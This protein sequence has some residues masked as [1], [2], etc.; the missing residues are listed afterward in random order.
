MYE[1]D[2]GLIY[3]RARYYSPAL[4][5]FV[6]AD[7]LHGDITNALSLNRYSFCNGDPAN[8]VDPLGLSW[9]RGNVSSGKSNAVAFGNED[10]SGKYKTAKMAVLGF[11]SEYYTIG[12]YL[13][14]ECSAIIYK[15]GE[16]YYIMNDSINK[17][18]NSRLRTTVPAGTEL[19]GYVHTHPNGTEFSD[20][21]IEAAK[22]LNCDAYVVLPS[23]NI[24][25]YD[26]NINDAYDIESSEGYIRKELSDSE[27]LLLKDAY[28]QEWE[29]HFDENG[30]YKCDSYGIDREDWP[31]LNY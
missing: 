1:D 10:V 30:C 27:R 23:G 7:K 24:R 31:N 20:A 3:M 22:K 8:G 18:H 5:R 29:N 28:R 4:R 17:P 21:D 15:S 6:N 13:R 12:M 9:E 16:L 11:A 19:V 14:L 2:T 26:I 25:K